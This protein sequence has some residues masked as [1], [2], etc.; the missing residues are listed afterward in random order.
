[1]LRFFGVFAPRHALRTE[2]A[3]LAGAIAAEIHALCL[4]VEI[5]ITLKKLAPLAPA[6]LP[7]AA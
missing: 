6:F 7:A 5:E 4:G 1:M 2:I 3:E